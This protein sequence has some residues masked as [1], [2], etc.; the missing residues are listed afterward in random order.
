MVPMEIKGRALSFGRTHPRTVCNE[1]VCSVK[2]LG[3]VFYP[4]GLLLCDLPP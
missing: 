1:N 2:Q 4:S 3:Y